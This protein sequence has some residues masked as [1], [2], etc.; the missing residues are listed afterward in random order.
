MLIVLLL[1]YIGMKRWSHV[2]TGKS[3]I[4]EPD[5]AAT[6]NG[7]HI[8]LDSLD[9]KHH[10]DRIGSLN[11]SGRTLRRAATTAPRSSASAAV[12]RRESTPTSLRHSLDSRLTD[13]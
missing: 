13:D 12:F 2:R 8:S 5:A 10:V 1:L 7:D 3:G 6:T 9:P 4:D 11:E